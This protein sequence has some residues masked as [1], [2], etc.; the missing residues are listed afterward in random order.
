MVVALLVTLFLVP[1]AFAHVHCHDH[2]ACKPLPRTWYH[3]RDH[4]VHALFDRDS[5]PDVGSDEWNKSWP[6]SYPIQT[7][8]ISTLPQPWVACYFV[9]H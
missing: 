9:W 6:S 3:A 5:F 7:P 1:F 2:K 8:D 4:P